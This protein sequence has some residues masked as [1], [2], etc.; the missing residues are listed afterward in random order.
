MLAIYNLCPD[1]RP[2]LTEQK[3]QPILKRIVCGK[4][5]IKSNLCL[6]E[7]QSRVADVLYFIWSVW[8]S[9]MQYLRGERI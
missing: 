3:K 5:F 6:I 2:V 9:Y 4:K 8:F 7:F 1:N